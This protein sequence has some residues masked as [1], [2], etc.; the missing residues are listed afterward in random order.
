M[1]DGVKRSVKFVLNIL[2]FEIFDKLVS[3]N[4]YLN[5]YFGEKGSK[6]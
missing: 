4:F 1:I 5:M 3:T 2:L 6:L